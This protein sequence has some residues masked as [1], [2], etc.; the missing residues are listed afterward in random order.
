MT[1]ELNEITA[2]D[3]KFAREFIFSTIT[4]EEAAKID[5]KNANLILEEIKIIAENNLFNAQLVAY[6]MRLYKALLTIK[7]LE[8][9]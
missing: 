4:S 1:L 8:N 7:E 9:E 3:I 2:E 5:T 6:G